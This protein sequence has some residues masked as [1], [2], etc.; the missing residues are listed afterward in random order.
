MGEL[1]HSAGMQIARVFP[2]KGK[3]QPDDEHAYFDV[4]P[5]FL[6]E[7]DE[8]H[9]SCAFTWDKKRAE[10]LAKQWE[11]RFQ[12][13]VKIG[14]PAF[15]SE[16]AEFEPGMYIRE[17][18][19]FTSRGCPNK[20]KFCFVPKIEGELKTL[21]VQRGHVINDNNFLACPRGHKKEV[22]AMLREAGKADFRGGLEAR[23]LTEW[24]AEQICSLK[25]LSAVYLAC[26]KPSRLKP[27]KRALNLLKPLKR[28]QKTCYV[29]IGYDDDSPDSAWSRIVDVAKAGA[30]PY[31]QLY[32][33]PEA[34]KRQHP[35]EWQHLQDAWCN[36]GK[37]ARAIRFIDAED[38]DGLARHRDIALG[39]SQRP[40]ARILSLPGCG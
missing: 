30:W 13:K 38:W 5:M 25:G 4:P 7:Y 3:Y 6:P 36:R 15:F 22:F 39:R 27:L 8:I 12:G 14:G 23:R 26:D 32:R 17:G 28:H 1:C 31:P 20:C 19:N 37:A 34:A 2:Q 24:D 21:K 10:W 11:S 40:D 35:R 16:A 29:L 33:P 18:V 9:V